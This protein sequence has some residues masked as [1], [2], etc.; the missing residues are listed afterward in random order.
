MS[1]FPSS[2]AS[3]PLW[4]ILG[5]SGIVPFVLAL[6]AAWFDYTPFDLAPLQLFVYYS[7]GILCFMAGTLWQQH[8]STHQPRY[9]IFSN[10]ICLL[11]IA[12]LALASTPAIGLLGL[13]YLMLWKVE[14]SA[15][16]PQP[17]NYNAMRKQISCIV[18]A[19]H[20]IALLLNL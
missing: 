9:L 18:A 15:N 7:V 20:G 16:L 5:F 12:S 10:I 14:A 6:L 2:P 8:L 11:A 1:D 13:L 19:L 3:T 17:P 4:K